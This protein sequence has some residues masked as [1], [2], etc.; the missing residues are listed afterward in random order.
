MQKSICFF[1]SIT[2][3]QLKDGKPPNTYEQANE[4]SIQIE[5]LKKKERFIL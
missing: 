2:H 1:Y 3:Q 4:K 5:K